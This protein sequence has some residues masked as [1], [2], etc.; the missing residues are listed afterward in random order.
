MEAIE[1]IRAFLSAK[2][3]EISPDFVELVDGYSASAPGWSWI[4][5]DLS[6]IRLL[7]RRIPETDAD[8]YGS[9][10]V[11]LYWL[12][13][14]P[15]V[16]DWQRQVSDLR[17][18]TA[19]LE[20][21]PVDAIIRHRSK[22]WAT[23]VRH[24]GLPRLLLHTRRILGMSS[25][26]QVFQWSSAD[27]R[28]LDAMSGFANGFS[29]ELE[30]R[31]AQKLEERLVQEKSSHGQG[32]NTAPKQPE[33]LRKLLVRDFRNI[34]EIDLYYRDN[35]TQSAVIHG[36][37]GTGKSNLFEAIEFALR[38]TSKRAQDFLSDADVST[39][40]KSQEYFERYLVPITH[41]NCE[42]MISLN[43][44][45]IP[46][47]IEKSS[48]AELKG[49]LLLQDRV[50]EFIEMK[51]SQLATEILGEFS[52]LA[53]NLRGYAEDELAQAQSN[54]KSMLDRLGLDRPGTITK[55]NTARG[56]VAEILLRDAVSPPAH[57]LAM[58]RNEAWAWSPNTSQTSGFVAAL[59]PER[60]QLEKYAKE[61][62][63]VTA[64]GEMANLVSMFLAPLRK[65][66]S[67][68]DQFLASI[69]GIR[70][71]WPPELATKLEVWGRWMEETRTVQKITDNQVIKEKQRQHKKLVDELEVLT[72]QGY[73]YRER[74]HHFESL[75]HL[76]QGVWK[77]S[78][79]QHC[80]T[81]DTDFSDRGG[82]LNAVDAIRT[83]NSETLKGLRKQ[84]GDTQ[85]QIKILNDELQMLDRV[86][87]PLAD[88]EQAAVRL[89]LSPHLPDG[90]NLDDTLMH[91]DDRN[92]CLAWVKLVESAPI[93][94][95]LDHGV[96]NEERI[97]ELV[98]RL[99]RA[100]RDMENGFQ[101]P[102]AWKK[103]TG[104]L[105]DRLAD[106]LEE[107][108][109]ETL[110]GLWIELVM[111]LTPAPWQM[112]GDL[113]M[114]V[115][116]R[117]GKQE[118]RVVLGATEKP[119]LARYVLN[120]AE[121]HAL[122]LSWFLV[123]YL[124]YG[125]FRHA[126][127]AMDDPALDMDQTT[128]RDFCRLLESL[129]RLHKTRG[130]PLVLLLFLHQDERALNA[131]RAMGGLLHRLDWNAGQASLER[132]IKLFSG[133]YRHPQ[134]SVFVKCEPINESNL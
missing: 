123:Q 43:G 30:K 32:A 87:C 35:T 112:V 74:E 107:H 69:A 79:N 70:S 41:D 34:K 103:V 115:E 67:G 21:L 56:K 65:A 12:V 96:D 91:P 131:A 2:Y 66:C 27:K 71:E 101:L 77:E 20:E 102:D 94:P 29:D 45:E 44:E 57:L 133:E 132:S 105:K 129:L 95:Q 124:S 39:T 128:F 48:V 110:G 38:G 127:L 59:Q 111:N 100:Y 18:E 15:D 114:R 122:G 99:Y 50:T 33:Q 125:R 10:R 16:E 72:K 58:L 24:H 31:L 97:A 130:I 17:R 26:D 119:R 42:T 82:I 113:D 36:P 84:Y 126:V 86:R 89:A 120:K 73:L 118:T 64:E 62:S 61:L 11:I 68:A 85:S 92:R 76:L 53:D 121:T 104:K 83:I 63:K 4:N 54:L 78:G 40:K 88:E 8:Q 14:H 108:L 7:P 134:P 60:E 93:P 19:H 117:R 51:A 13:D 55:Q 37:N 90:I 109:P 28:V 80:P 25:V 98:G 52:G 47:T 9:W 75:Q 1:E 49:S 116:S 106:V 81:C 22:D 3:H 46:L 23:A 5:E 6:L